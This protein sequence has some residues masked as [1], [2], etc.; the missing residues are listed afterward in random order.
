VS[1]AIPLH[2]R[3]CPVEQPDERVDL[4]TGLRSTTDGC[5]AIACR[6]GETS[7]LRTYPLGPLIDV[8]K[9]LPS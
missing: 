5:A 1:D 3:R 9:E 4:Q 7:A 6:Q 2:D 8:L